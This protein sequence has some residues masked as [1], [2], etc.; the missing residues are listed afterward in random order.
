MSPIVSSH[1][2]RVLYIKNEITGSALRTAIVMPF[3]DERKIIIS[4]REKNCG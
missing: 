2:R 3:L 4:T 1:H